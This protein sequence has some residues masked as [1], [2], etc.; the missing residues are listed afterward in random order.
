[1]SVSKRRLDE[2]AAATGFRPETLEKVLRLGDILADVGRHPLLGQVL[3]LKGGTALNLC[4]GPPRRLSVDLD[5]N[6]IGSEDRARMLEERPS[7]ERAVETIARGKGYEVQHSRDEHAGRKLYLGYTSA[8]GTRDRIEIDLNYLHRVLLVAP[9]ELAAWRP[10]NA[11][12]PRV[13]LVGAEELCSG[14]LCALL[15]RAAPR[16]LHD[17]ARLPAILQETW[18]LPILRPLVIAMAGTLPHPIHK[19]GE[20][21]FASLTDSVVEEQLHPM[22]ASTE[23]PTAEELTAM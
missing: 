17:V 14:K 12:S 3:A 23:R 22:L 6:Y 13:R 2:L 11:P 9:I 7:V 4:F 19:Y 16:D 20:D 21:R 8:P 18:N 5:F 10:D 15:D 1:M